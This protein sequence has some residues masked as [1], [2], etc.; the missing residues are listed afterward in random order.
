[1][2]SLFILLIKD[3]VKLILVSVAIGIPIVYSVMNGWLEGF[4]YHTSIP[5]SI[6]ILAGIA[7]LVI[8]LLTISVE[9]VRSALS[10]PV[11][12]LRYE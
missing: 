3:Y 5:A 1:M 11:D 6:F 4:A 8:S 9:T 7:V 10:N 12:A 2:L